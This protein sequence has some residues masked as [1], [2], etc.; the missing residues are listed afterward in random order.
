MCQKTSPKLSSYAH[1]MPPT[2]GAGLQSGVVGPLSLEPDSQLGAAA[3][4]YAPGTNS[5]S[6]RLVAFSP[7]PLSSKNTAGRVETRRPVGCKESV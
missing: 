5:G 1:T 3:S 2:L 7:P 6:S 4:A